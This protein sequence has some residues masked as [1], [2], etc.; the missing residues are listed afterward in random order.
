[1]SFEVWQDKRSKLS[2]CL[3]GNKVLGHV[4]LPSETIV[5]EKG[6]VFKF[7]NGKTRKSRTFIGRIAGQEYLAGNIRHFANISR[8]QHN[9]FKG[10]PNVFY[11]FITVSGKEINYW[12]MPYDVISKVLRKL[13]VKS[14]S[15]SFLRIHEE[16]KR[17]IAHGI[18]ITRYRRR[19]RFSDSQSRRY[20]KAAVTA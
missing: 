15:S 20:R 4:K 6:T 5:H 13:P 12:P 7:R 9:A 17:F 11:L 2:G 14:D 8:S 1:M 19:I 16:D 18:D 10:S 3:V